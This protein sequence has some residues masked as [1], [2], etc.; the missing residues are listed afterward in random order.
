MSGSNKQRGWR[1]WLAGAAA[2]IGSAAAI[3]VGM[4]QIAEAFPKVLPFWAPFDASI[5][6]RDIRVAKVIS[7]DAKVDGSTTTP[8]AQVQIEFVEEKTGP[9]PLNACLPELKLQDVFKPRPEQPQTITK[10][11]QA[12]VL[13]TF[14]V[15]EDQYGKDGS[16]RVMCERRVTGWSAF[17]LPETIGINKPEIVTY[18]V[19]SGE[20]SQ[21]CGGNIAWVPC[22]A[23][24]GNWAKTTHPAECVN[25][26][27]ASRD[28]Y[29]RLKA[30]DRGPFT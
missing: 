4:V 23:D 12:I 1:Q 25:V 9:S 3:A 21:A 18:M 8:A 6:I 20:Y 5:T 22:Y 15:P 26:K 2:F 16:I 28:R 27:A 17:T 29:N 11:T 7:V 13:S 10:E 19:C 24:I 30:N 14:L